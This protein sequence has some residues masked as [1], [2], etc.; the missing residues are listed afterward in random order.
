M[1][2][3]DIYTYARWGRTKKRVVPQNFKSTAV[4]KIKLYRYWHEYTSTRLK[5]DAPTPC[6]KV[7][8]RHRFVV[9]ICLL[10]G[11]CYLVVHIVGFLSFFPA[12]FYVAPSVSTVFCFR[13][14]L[15]KNVKCYEYV[16]VTHNIIYLAEGCPPG[17][18]AAATCTFS[19]ATQQ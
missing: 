11:I 16:L 15:T 14:F 17:C 10:Q 1:D 5:R 18:T 9:V 6:R 4:Q 2:K 19:Q 7:T 8:P 13:R 3:P 12:F